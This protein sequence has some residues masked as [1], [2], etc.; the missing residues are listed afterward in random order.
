[1][2]L[3]TSNIYHC[4]ATHPKQGLLQKKG[5]SEQNCHTLTGSLQLV[6]I[7]AGVLTGPALLLCF[8]CCK[9]APGSEEASEFVLLVWLLRSSERPTSGDVCPAACSG[10]LADPPPNA[11]LPAVPPE[12]PYF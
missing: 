3:L 5:P 2:G 7:Q 11:P 9:C 10:R 8:P 6:F 12:E 4:A 1:M